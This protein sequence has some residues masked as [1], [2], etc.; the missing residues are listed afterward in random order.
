MN[1]PLGTIP[2]SSPAHLLFPFGVDEKQIPV[3]F[4]QRSTRT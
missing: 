2:A 3:C 4:Q 1:S